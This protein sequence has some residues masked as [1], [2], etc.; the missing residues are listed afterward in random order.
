MHG[1]FFNGRFFKNKFDL[2]YLTIENKIEFK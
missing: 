1:S 2:Q